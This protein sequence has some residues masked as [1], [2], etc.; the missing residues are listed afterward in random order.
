MKIPSNH[1]SE[2][3]RIFEEALKM[4]NAYQEFAKKQGP[5]PTTILV[6]GRQIFTGSVGSLANYMVLKEISFVTI[7]QRILTKSLRI[8]L[9]YSH[10]IVFDKLYFI[11]FGGTSK[12][13]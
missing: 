4:R 9:H 5:L 3:G 2:S 10:P 7:G 6:L 11:T 12:S 1:Q 8:R 13:S